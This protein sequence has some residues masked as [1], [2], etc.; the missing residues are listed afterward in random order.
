MRFTLA[1]VLALAFAL[2]AIPAAE[3][4]YVTG[5]A[6]VVNGVHGSYQH[7]RFNQVVFVPTNSVFLNT[8]YGASAAFAPSY[9]PSYGTCG[10]ASAPVYSTPVLAPSYG[11]GVS[12]NPFFSFNR[13]IVIRR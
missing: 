6:V 13:T 4:Q 7:N 5:R 3:A 10:V 8:G 11:Y 2:V 9:A 1:S 12:F